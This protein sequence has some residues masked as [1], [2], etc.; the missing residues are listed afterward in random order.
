MLRGIEKKDVIYRW[1]VGS[2]LN[3]TVMGEQYGGK[4][5]ELTASKGGNDNT[6]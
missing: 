6:E 5:M 1:T 3:V 4:L 2:I